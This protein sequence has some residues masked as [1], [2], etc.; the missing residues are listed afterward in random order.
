M[1]GILYKKKRPPDFSRIRSRWHYLVSSW[2]E[3]KDL[4]FYAFNYFESIYSSFAL[5]YVIAKPCGNRVVAIS[6]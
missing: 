5:R 2:A 3:S 4:R 6:K 1:L